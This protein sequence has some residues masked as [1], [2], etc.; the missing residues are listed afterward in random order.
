LPFARS[1]EAGD[2][3]AV[4]IDGRR[5][6]ARREDDLHQRVTG[7]HEVGPAG[8]DLDGEPRIRDQRLGLGD[9]DEAGGHEGGGTDEDE[10]ATGW[11]SHGCLQRRSSACPP[12]S[13]R[14]PDL[15][16]GFPGGLGGPAGRDGPLGGR[17]RFL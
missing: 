6:D 1:E 10:M 8:Q 9:R 11:A 14:L 5:P 17:P 3:L 2:V 16:P 4:D 13:S 15:L 12:V 7:G